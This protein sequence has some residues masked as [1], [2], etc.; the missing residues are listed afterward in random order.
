MTG[1]DESKFAEAMIGGAELYG[2]EMTRP[3]LSLYFQALKKYKLADITRALSRH[4]TNPDSGQYFPKPADVVR[5]LEGTSSDSA[6]VAWS[7]VDKAARMVGP[8]QTVVFDDPL[9]HRVIEDMGG[10]IPLGDKQEKEWPFVANEFRER[11]RGYKSLGEEPDYPGKLIGQTEANNGEFDP[12]WY[13]ERG[14]PVPA[15]VLIGSPQQAQRVLAGGASKPRLQ[16][17]SMADAINV[18]ARITE[19]DQHD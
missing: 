15:P 12:E 8:H 9:I 14:L 16:I 1:T 7:K 13:K 18:Q 3:L 4:V 6:Q 17:T 11:Y 19:G 2:K 10:W 5:M